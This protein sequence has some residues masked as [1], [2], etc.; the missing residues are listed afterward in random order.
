MLKRCCFLGCISLV[1]GAIA[2]SAATPATQP[3]LDPD[4]LAILKAT[5]GSLADAKTFSFHVR[6]ARDRQ[7]TNNQIITYFNQDA[8]T[9]SRPNKLRIDIDGEHHDVQFY[10]D[11]TKATLFTPETKLYVSHAAPATIDEML[12]TMDERG[13]SF[14][15]NN[16]LEN[17]PY[18]TLIKG[19]QTAYVVGRV[20]IN[21]K[22][23]IH[24]V[25]TEAS[26][27]W[28]LWVE[29]G[30]KPLPKGLIIVYKT[31]PGSPRVTMDFS[32]WNLNA[33]PD[34]QTFD[35]VKPEDAHEIQ[36]FPMKAGK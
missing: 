16:L 3:D 33:Q 20:N 26:A 36:F 23:F 15:M 8:V 13:V 4:A 29:P 14:P 7:A 30:D 2:I 11:G 9:V 34:A 35:F 18:D 22:T 19:L 5:M 6:V 21:D 31:E 10:F 17:R 1:V 32:D 24:L 27:D 12:K 28:Q 25:F